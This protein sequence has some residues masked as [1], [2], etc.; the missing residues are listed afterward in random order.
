MG[1]CIPSWA[2]GCE[3][4]PSVCRQEHDFD[5]VTWHTQTYL[6][7]PNANATSYFGQ[8]KQKPWP[9]QRNVSLLSVACRDDVREHTVHGSK[10]GLRS[11]L[12]L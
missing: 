11:P 4:H 7:T 8:N 3:Q 5:A 2:T 6:W 12:G 10:V 1:C 9:L